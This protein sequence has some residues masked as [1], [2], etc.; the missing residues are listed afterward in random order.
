MQ[1]AQL[2]GISLEYDTRGDGEAV[3]LI[4]PAPFADSFLPLMDQP[5]LKN[6][7]LILYHRRGYSGSSRTTGRV[8]VADHAH[9]LAGLLNYLGIKRAHLA[10]H[11]N[12]G[13]V[14]LQLALDRP[15]LVASLA[16]LEPALMASPSVA[17]GPSGQEL[18]KQLPIAFKMYRE[19]DLEGA[20]KAFLAPLFAPGYE[21]LIEKIKPGGWKQSV[22]DANTFFGF[23]SGPGNFQFAKAD[24]RKITAPVLSVRGALSHPVFSEF[25]QVLHDWFP[26]LETA[27]IPDVDHRL[28]M[29]RPDLVAQ[30]LAEFLVKHPLRKEEKR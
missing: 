28:Y 21:Q 3:V 2:D 5:A 8:T 4:H 29:V 9:D 25:E 14:A 17:P 27:L 24:A 18:M 26:Q 6:Y 12:G 7:K 1:R 30:A 23:E 11:S 20:A 13:L 22:Q 10:G 19:G 16:L 15:E